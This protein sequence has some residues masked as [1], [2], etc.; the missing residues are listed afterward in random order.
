MRM[1]AENSTLNMSCKAGQTTH[2]HEILN[3]VLIQ[4]KLSLD[5]HRCVLD[6][7][8]QKNDGL[9]TVNDLQQGRDTV[10]HCIKC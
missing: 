2:L 10:C 1:P 4:V 9:S 5:V 3:L 6:R 8:Q 7:Y